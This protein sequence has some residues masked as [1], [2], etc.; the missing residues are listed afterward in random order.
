[1][2]TVLIRPMSFYDIGGD[3]QF[4]VSFKKTKKIFTDRNSDNE[5]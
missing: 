4:K 3:S 1:M 5:F 2:S